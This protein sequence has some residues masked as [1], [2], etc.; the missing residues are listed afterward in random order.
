VDRVLDGV[1]VTGPLRRVSE[2]AETAPSDDLA[3]C[4]SNQDGIVKGPLSTQPIRSFGDRMRR[5]G[6]FNGPRREQDVLEID[7]GGQI[8]ICSLTHRRFTHAQNRSEGEAV[9]CRSA[10]CG[11]DQHGRSVARRIPN[12]SFAPTS[13]QFASANGCERQGAN[14]MGTTLLP[15][16]LVELALLITT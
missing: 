14:R 3:C 9:D 13:P 5:L 12:G 16:G 10:I 8:R 2:V 7:D 15:V 11:T 6:P 1:P 4:D